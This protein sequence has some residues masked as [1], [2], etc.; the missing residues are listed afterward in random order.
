[1]KGKLLTTIITLALA[2]AA[3]NTALT[4]RLIYADE[5]TVAEET[6]ES[7]PSASAPNVADAPE[8]VSIMGCGKIYVQPDTAELRFELQ[9]RGSSVAEAQNTVTQT[10]NRILD[11]IK[12][13]DADA[14]K[15]AAYEYSYA[16]PVCENGVTKYEYNRNFSFITHKLDALDKLIAAASNAGATRYGGTRLSLENNTDAYKQALISAKNNALEKAAALYGN[17]ELQQLT[18]Q[19]SYCY[20]SPDMN[21]CITVEVSVCACFKAR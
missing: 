15:S 10:Y 20:C 3:I 2:F 18:E 16:Y 17:L 19:G 6:Q 9:V 21:G 5:Q 14:A 1:M 4:P 12:K 13:V 8:C 7:L 11:S